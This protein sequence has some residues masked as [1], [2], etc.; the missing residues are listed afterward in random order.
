MMGSNPHHGEAN[1]VCVKCKVPARHKIAE[2]LHLP[3]HPMTTYL[4]CACMKVL[5]MDCEWYE[6]IGMYDVPQ[7]TF[8]IGGAEP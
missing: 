3:V 2:E 6:S 4:C 1:E 8:P 7:F 5:G